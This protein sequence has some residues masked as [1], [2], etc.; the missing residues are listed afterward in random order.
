MRKNSIARIVLLLA[1]LSLTPTLGFS[2]GKSSSQALLKDN[3]DF[4]QIFQ[5]VTS[6]ANKST[7]EVICKDKTV[8]LGTVIS[9]DGLILTLL[10][11]LDGP[12]T[13]RLTEGKRL[14]ATVVAQ[15]EQFNLV[16]LRVDANLT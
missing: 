4:L 9:A 13:I 15:H 11:E 2:Q 3:P 8:A 16:L 7:V 10:S 12:A 6:P 14:D 5:P 1:A